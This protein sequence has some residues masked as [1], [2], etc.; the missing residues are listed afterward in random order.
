MKKVIPFNSAP[1]GRS[2][3]VTQSANA[4]AKAVPAVGL[5]RNAEQ[6]LL[7]LH[8]LL[9]C[10][11]QGELIQRFVQWST[12]LGIT[13]G[14]SFQC[15]KSDERISLGNRR[16][17]SAQYELNL[18]HTTLGTITLYRRERYSE[19]ELL[20]L[21]QALGA[22]ARCLQLAADV[23]ALR[24]LATRD[25]LTGL[26]N[27]NSLDDW[28][29]KEVSRTR[30]HGM[31][32]ALM[33]IDVDHFKVLND[34]LG[35]PAGDHILKSIAGVFEQSTRAS[36]LSFRFGGDEFAI[37]LPHTELDNAVIVAEQIRHNLSRLSDDELQITNA[38][39]G[40]RPDISIGIAAFRDGD[41]DETLLRRADTH[42]YHAK[43][44]GRG[45]VCSNL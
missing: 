4:G 25:A 15:A 28:L 6:Q 12:D 32:M 5:T 7:L 36:D 14:A 1:E 34:R 41:S 2:G 38:A 33:M 43:A 40:L 29:H 27:R 26:R 17:H 42:L 10:S 37:L 24:S 19:D 39:N 23:A 11:E 45:C 8:R 31:P 13:D 35:H 16:N 18:D 22:L 9:G 21:E 3:P 44:M 30:R 20:V